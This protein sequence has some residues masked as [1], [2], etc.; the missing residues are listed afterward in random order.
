[1]SLNNRGLI[2]KRSRVYALVIL[3]A[4]IILVF[5]TFILRP[6]HTEI[7]TTSQCGEASWY[8]LR[9][10]TANG[11][12]MDPSKLTA[13]H[14]T[15]PM[16]TQV[17]VTNLSNGKTLTVRVNDRGPYAKS[18]L[19]DLSKAAAIELDFMDNGVTPVRITVANEFKKYLTGHACKK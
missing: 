2:R 15:L 19:I 17:M 3:T 9:S 4:A 1:M 6:H 13:A 5:V 16:E 8:A 18:R 11:E 12:M 10:Q 14:L 7:A